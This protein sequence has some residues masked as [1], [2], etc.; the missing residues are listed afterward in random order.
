MSEGYIYSK[1]DV[2]Y[3]LGITIYTIENWYRWERKEIQEGKVAK[4]YLPQPVKLENTKGKPLRWSE[5]MIEELEEYQKTIIHGRNGKY[6]CYTNLA[7]G[8][9]KNI[10]DVV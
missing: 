4:N 7:S 3:L 10:E 2:C 8:K 9:Q 5:E 6:G 1:S